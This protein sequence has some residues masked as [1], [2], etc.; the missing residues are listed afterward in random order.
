MTAG[1]SSCDARISLHH[2][3]LG[4]SSTL[5]DDAAGGTTNEVGTR[6]TVQRWSGESTVTPSYHVFPEYALLRAPEDTRR[7]DAYIDVRTPSF[8]E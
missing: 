4:T 7:V 2:E 6:A 8:C 3:T 5:E 1:V